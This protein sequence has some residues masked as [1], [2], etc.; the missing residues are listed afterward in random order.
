MAHPRP[1]TTAQRILVAL[2]TPDVGHAVALSRSLTGIVGGV[3]LGLEFFNHNGPEGVRRVARAGLAETPRGAPTATQPFFLDL[4]YH[5]IPNTVAGAV[6]AAVALGPMILNVHAS[7]G[8]A[9]M[10]AAMDA[11]H[12]AAEPLGVARPIMIAVTVLTS[13][14]DEDLSAVGQAGPTADQAV[15]LA[16][17]AQQSGM[18]GVVCSP[19]E[20]TRIRAACGPD[21]RLITP[22]VRPAGADR[23]DQKRIMTPVEAVQAGA[24]WL[25][26]GRPITQAADPASA[27]RAIAEE[28]AA[29]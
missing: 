7:G 20:I 1:N 9:M 8:A 10:K 23:G 25:V 19:H 15:R 16:E 12:F 5:D 6:R 27:A 18:D 11:A 21:F 13:L 22:G 26:I 3:K 2:D 29:A 28:L 17:L 24:D 14:D 4:K